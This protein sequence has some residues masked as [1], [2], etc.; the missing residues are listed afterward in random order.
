M[1]FGGS[2]ATSI[3]VGSST[4]I[5]ALTPQHAAGTVDVTVTNSDGQVGTLA[6]SYT[7]TTAGS[8]PPTVTSISPNNGPFSGGTSVSITGTNFVSGATVTFGGVAANSMNVVST[9]SITATTPSHAAGSVDV[10]VTNPDGQSATLPVNRLANPGFELGGVNWKNTSTGG[11]AVVQTNSAN[12][13]SGSNYAEL[14]SAA[15]N[16]PT[17]N[18][19]DASG[20]PIYFPVNPGDLIN[21]GGWANRIS[22]NG[23]VR[24]ILAAYDANKANPIRTSSGNASTTSGWGYQQNSYTV[25]AGYAYVKFYAEIYN[26]TIAADVYFDDAVLSGGFTYTLP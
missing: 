12:A 15:G 18:A 4:S 11:T 6:G 1:S 3:A 5:T 7:F 20:N 17:F 26:N 24:Y 22:G 13:H 16:H 21:F 23:S 25:P 9:T 10:T 2:Q 8:D 19:A 14:T